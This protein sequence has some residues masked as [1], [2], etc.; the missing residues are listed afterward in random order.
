MKKILLAGIM[1]VALAFTGQTQAQVRVGVNINIGSQPAWGPTGYDYVN[2]YYIPDIDIFYYVPRH[3]YVYFDG[4]R[5]IFTRRIPERFRAFDF[6]HAHK[7]VLN[8][9]RP[10][11]R[12]DEIRAKYVTFR[13]KH[14]E[15]HIYNS[16]DNRY[17]HYYK[18]NK[19]TQ[20]LP[21][22]QERP[23]RG[24]APQPPMHH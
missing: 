24:R 16:P 6:Y 14:E 7:V 12:H 9:D 1:F 5:W 21:P 15:M 19:R 3:E 17:S 8:E 13:G 2:Y 22:V 23:G 20:P 11:L 10:Y 18:G 4:G